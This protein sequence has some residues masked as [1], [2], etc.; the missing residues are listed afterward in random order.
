MIDLDINSMYPILD[1][2]VGGHNFN[3]TYWP[4]VKMISWDQYHKAER[5]CYANFKSRN[6]RNQGLWFAFKKETDFTLFMLKWA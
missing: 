4:Y 3:K 2:I 6:W 1:K 5:W